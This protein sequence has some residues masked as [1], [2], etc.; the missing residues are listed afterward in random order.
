[1]K[2]ILI[3]VSVVLFM[4]PVSV[5]ATTY[6]V[7]SSGGDDGNN[8]NST[9]TAWRTISKV[10]SEMGK[11][12]PGDRILFRRERTFGGSESLDITCNGSYAFEY[13]TFGSYGS[14]SKPVFNAANFDQ[15][16]GAIKSHASIDHII[17]ENITIRDATNGGGSGIVFKTGN[18]TNIIISGCEIYN[19]G[20][21]C[22]VLEEVDT[23]LIENSELYSC[24]NSGIE[25]RASA[26]GENPITNGV[27]VNNIIHDVNDGVAFHQD[28]SGTYDVGPNHFLYNNTAYN[29]K[30]DSFDISSG[31]GIVLRDNEGYGS[32][33]AGISIANG[34]QNL[35][36]EDHYDHDEKG[37]A[38]HVTDAN[39]VVISGTVIEN[40]ASQLLLIADDTDD[41]YLAN[42]VLVYGTD[43][44]TEPLYVDRLKSP[45]GELPDNL[46]ARNNIFT[47]EV[48]NQPVAMIYYTSGQSPSNTNSDF[49]YNL[50][51][52]PGRDPVSGNYFRD[53]TDNRTISEWRANW[54]QEL[55]SS[56]ANPNLDSVYFP[57][58]GSPAIDT[59]GWLTTITSAPGSGTTFAVGDA[60]W[61]HDGFGLTMGSLIELEGGSEYLIAMDV[62]YGTN[63]ITVDR[64]I[65]W[66]QGEGVAFSYRGSAPDR[67]AFEYFPS[68]VFQGDL[69]GD[70]F[71][72]MED[73]AIIALD[74]GKRSG[75]DPRADTDGNGEIDIY[76]L[77]F[78]ASRLTYSHIS[79]S[80]STPS[81]GTG[82]IVSFP[83]SIEGNEKEIKAFGIYNFTFDSNMLQYL[84]V[85]KGSLTEEWYA[86]DGNEISPGN[87]ISGGFLGSSDPIPIGSI[88]SLEIFNLMVTC[89]GCFDG[90][91]TQVCI[92]NYVDDLSG[93][94]PEPACTTFTYIEGASYSFIAFA[95]VT[96]TGISL[97]SDPSSGDT[98]INV[99]L[100]VSIEGNS[101]EID[102]FGLDMNYS[103]MMLDFRGVSSGSLTWD[104]FAVDGNEISP[105][106]V[107]IG[108]FTGSGDGIRN[109]SNGD[110]AVAHFVVNC[111]DCVDGQ[112]GEICIGNYVDDIEFME[113]EP[114]CTTFTYRKSFNYS[115]ISIDFIPSS[116]GNGNVVSL[117]V[118]INGNTEEISAFGLDM[119][120]S[121]LVLRYQNVSRGNLT[122]DWFAVDGN[123]ISP[124]YVK[125]G[126]FA[127]FGDYI[128]A[129]SVG[130]VA[131]IHFLVNCTGCADGQEE[132]ICI[133][134][135]VDGIEGMEPYPSCANFTYIEG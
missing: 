31:T 104:W 60:K 89:S 72:D 28:P 125:A 10:N 37:G 120:Y 86:V 115:S 114:A 41:I 103:G 110:I 88:G 35:F 26:T 58:D 49:D 53:E 111:T 128:P 30:E 47:S 105:G 56:I 109:D 73:M 59:G 79:I 24:Q 90:Q 76:D 21:S 99:S 12:E 25:I 134:N 38:I 106:Y 132:E 8:G 91:Q 93:I 80:C 54:N 82:A 45:L 32:D 119:N 42:N 40:P 92:D 27:V 77:V 65:S 96:Y 130:S 20:A 121:A 44:N 2:I 135:Y 48:T 126:G 3:L 87:V 57:L 71:V 131:V 36:I 62:D 100:P 14:G 63:V 118:S 55:Q 1:M 9:S 7:D 68:P 19:T 46:Q 97:Y 66:S 13:I 64:S 95:P 75:F 50:F 29:C 129:D 43:G 107:K 116:G 83:V 85:T 127:G 69:S 22:I 84:N 5:F 101:Q 122:G 94:T 108:G 18:K 102:A 70:G 52:I 39:H 15:D 74:F 61:F 123:E 124:G 16:E 98:G 33:N 78:V 17:I 113:P 81:E 4:L 112:E 117:P 51:Y 6:Y 34:V 23:Y 11:F 133:W 67:G